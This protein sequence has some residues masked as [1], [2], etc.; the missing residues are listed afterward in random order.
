MAMTIASIIPCYR[1][2]SRSFVAF[3]ATCFVLFGCNRFII[4]R[5][6]LESISYDRHHPLRIYYFASTLTS[7][8]GYVGYKV[9]QPVY[10]FKVN[11]PVGVAL[12]QQVE[13]WLIRHKARVRIPGQASKRNMKKNFSSA[14]SS[15]QFSGKNS[16]SKI[17]PAMKKFLKKK[18]SVAQSRL[19]SVSPTTHV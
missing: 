15:Q 10:I 3:T 8:R 11:T 2:T 17:K 19:Q 6:V 13:C 4:I 18:K 12:V 5:N 14:I 9:V 16:E 1:G 7:R